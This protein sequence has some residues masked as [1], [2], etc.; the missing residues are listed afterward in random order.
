MPLGLADVLVEEFGSLDVEE[1]ALAVLAAVALGLGHLLGERVG[2]G[3]GDER[4]SASGWPVEQDA[5]GGSEFVLLEQVRVEV[6][7]FDRIADHL[8]L[9]A[10]T[11]DLCVVDVR[12]LFEDQL[13]DLA[14]GDAFVHVPGAR[15]EEQ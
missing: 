9:V 10:Q 3:L 2:D 4:L 8:D 15:F 14:L 13:F 11:A 1:V 5:L 6:R 7:Q 12:H